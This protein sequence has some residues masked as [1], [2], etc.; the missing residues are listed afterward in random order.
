MEQEYKELQ[1]RRFLTE[2]EGTAIGYSIKNQMDNQQDIDS[3]YE[4]IEEFGY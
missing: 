3:I 1:I 4:Q 2:Y